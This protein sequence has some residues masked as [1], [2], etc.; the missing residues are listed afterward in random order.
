MT[1][2]A[3]PM[4]PEPPP[5]GR[6]AQ[7]PGLP[8]HTRHETTLPIP[9]LPPGRS[10]EFGRGLVTAVVQDAAT[11]EVLMVAHMD[12]EAYAATLSTGL[13]AFHSRSRDRLWVKGEASGNAMAVVEI[14]VDCDGDA[15]LLRVKPAGPA[16]HTG[17]RSCF[18]PPAE[19][20]PAQ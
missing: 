1:P 16:C 4:T 13:A 2:D 10:P 14:H 9:V 7:E 8:V 18:Q 20:I 6:T 19:T 11:A 5:P 12:E 17:A 3:A 15:L